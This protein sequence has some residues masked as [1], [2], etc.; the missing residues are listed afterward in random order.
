MYLKEAEVRCLV[1]SISSKVFNGYLY[2]KPVGEVGKNW[3]VFD[4]HVCI[5]DNVVRQS[6]LSVFSLRYSP[7][8]KVSILVME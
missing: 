4:D 8:G 6:D 3:H 7:V 5:D 2:E 1:E